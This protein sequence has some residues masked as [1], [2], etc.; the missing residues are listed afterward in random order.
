MVRTGEP[1]CSFGV[2]DI[3]HAEVDTPQ[4][5]PV[6]K[7]SR[8]RGRTRL[9]HLGIQALVGPDYLL[10]SYHLYAV[11]RVYGADYE[12]LRQVLLEA[13]EER[14]GEAVSLCGQRA[15]PLV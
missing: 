11:G 13:L 12:R 14:F 4:S 8:E 5:H 10:N 3:F 15:S 1:F 7:P 6:T 9:R 2:V